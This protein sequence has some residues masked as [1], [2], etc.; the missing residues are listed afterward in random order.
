M[1]SGWVAIGVLAGVVVVVAALMIGVSMTSQPSDDRPGFVD[2][3]VSFQYPPDWNVAAGDG[4]DPV[5][6]RVIRTS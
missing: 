1:D 6:H 4:T 5:G 3:Q 2:E